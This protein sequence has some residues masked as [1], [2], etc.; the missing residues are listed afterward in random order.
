M[1]IPDAIRPMMEVWTHR[2]YA[3]FMGGMSPALV[4]LW[5]Q[6]IG[7]LWLAWDL[8]KSNTWVGLVVAVDYA[9]MI[10]LAPFV[11]AFTEKSNPVEVQKIAQ[12][13]SLIIAAAMAALVFTGLMN[14]WLLLLLSLALGC[15]HPFNAISRHTIVP[16]TVPRAVLPSALATDSALYNAARFIGPA[17]A[18]Y[19]ISQSGVGYTFVAN[20]VGILFYL[21]G[22]FAVRIDFTDRTSHGHGG[23][24]GDIVE[25]LTY[26]RSHPGI[27]PLFML[28]T[29]GAIWV[30]PLQDLL[31]GF[32]DKVF[33][34]GPQG[35]GW[36]TAGMGVGAML[37]A[38]AIAM[39]GRTHG[40]TL[41][42]LLAFLVNLIATVAFC[43]TG[44]LWLA[45]LCGALWGGTLTMMS[46]G[47]QALVQSSVDN[48]LRAR[49]MSLYT[50][51][52]RGVPALGAV[53]IGWLADR[54]G[55]QLAFIIATL[56]CVIPWITAFA[57]RASITLALEGHGNNLDERLL[58]AS[59]AMA[60][61][62]YE[63]MVDLKSRA[64]PLAGMLKHQ[65][66][67]LAAKARVSKISEKLQ[68]LKHRA[69]RDD[70]S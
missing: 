47:T 24:L 25:G 60:G 46:T 51:I 67:T 48:A 26:V 17:L 15:V 16:T 56:L 28:M 6:R 7:T 61:V 66:K 31:P 41:A 30:R 39:Y 21:A 11:G 44:W 3:L 22:L 34:A 70:L 68:A 2:N 52:Y 4:T 27:G 37:A 59:R 18:G 13:L 50:M 57:K 1:T 63:Q 65:T 55:L 45:V 64:T 14:I 53:V 43:S 40:L 58:A 8:T 54:I 62:A 29:I 12:Y 42:V 33:A 38:G 9:P 5:M 49:V 20:A 32:A 69:R 19:V 10:V 23:L 36:L 35:L